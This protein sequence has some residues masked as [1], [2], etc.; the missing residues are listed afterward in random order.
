[1]KGLIAVP[2][3]TFSWRL[4]AYASRFQHCS[5]Y[6]HGYKSQFQFGIIWRYIDIREIDPQHTLHP[7]A[8]HNVH[9]QINEMSS[10]LLHFELKFP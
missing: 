3:S 4:V 7:F 2:D 5:S 1:M 10:G 9:T 8:F 6:N